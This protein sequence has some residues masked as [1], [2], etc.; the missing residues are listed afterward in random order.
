MSTFHSFIPYLII[1]TENMSTYF[2]FIS[3]FRHALNY[4]LRSTVVITY[5]I[6]QISYKS[7]SEKT[8]CQSATIQIAGYGD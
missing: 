3:I 1:G 2:Q 8:I 7:T 6:E 5:F 4:F